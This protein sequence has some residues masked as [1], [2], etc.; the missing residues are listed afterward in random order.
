M[1]MQI[2]FIMLMLLLV[3][4]AV[5]MVA[6]N[7]MDGRDVLSGIFY[8]NVK[9]LPVVFMP[10]QGGNADVFSAKVGHGP[11]RHAHTV[12]HPIP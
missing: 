8:A 4:H 12:I 7:S 6:I 9:G 11:R 1:K 10:S 5:D 3:A 2:A